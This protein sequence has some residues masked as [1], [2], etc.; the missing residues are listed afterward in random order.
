MGFARLRAMHRIVDGCLEV[1]ADPASW[2]ARLVD[3]ARALFRAQVGLSGEFTDIYSDTDSIVH[4][5]VD[6]GWET[7][8]QQQH[9]IRYQVEGAHLRDPMRQELAKHGHR[10]VARSAGALIG[11][12]AYRA[13]EIYRN[14]VEPSGL[15]DQLVG[16]HSYESQSGTRWQTMTVFRRIGD[17]P[18]SRDDMKILFLLLRELQRH[19]GERLADTHSP[20][21]TLTPRLREALHALLSGDREKDCA[22]RLGVSTATYHKYVT[23][24]YRHFD[25]SGR[26]ELQARFIRG[27][28]PE[29][30]NVHADARAARL[31][32]EGAPM[33]QPW[34][35]GDSILKLTGHPKK[36]G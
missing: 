16:I 26:A 2:R 31:R 34:R 27:L 24:I 12:D 28:V 20:M 10:A 32:R 5:H 4:H 35:A 11:L 18:F 17:P 33:S 6:A 14:Y 8:D 19:A 36:G 3:E 22:D 25:V 9:F 7:P 13:S 29:R 1:G 30:P 15:D 23:A 21:F